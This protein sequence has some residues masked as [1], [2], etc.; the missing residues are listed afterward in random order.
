MHKTKYYI[1]MLVLLYTRH[2]PL[3]LPYIHAFDQVID[4]A[5]EY[6]LNV[7]FGLMEV[8]NS[9]RFSEWMKD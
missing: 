8:D 9:V 6:K 4:D 7:R 2:S 5:L 1:P 3:T